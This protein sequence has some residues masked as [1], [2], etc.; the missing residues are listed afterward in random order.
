LLDKH[1]DLQAVKTKMNKIYQVQAK[2]E[3]D[4][5]RQA[6]YENKFIWGLAPL[7][8]MHLDTEYEGVPEA[9]D[10]IYSYILT[11]IAV[12]ILLIACINFVN[13]T[14]AQSLKRNKEIGIRK[15]VGSLRSQLV[16]Q[17]LGE[18]LMVCL[19]SFLAA[20]LLASLAL[21][22]FG[23]MAGK[24][25]SLGS[26]FDLQL[27]AGL[28]LLFIFTGILAGFY[29]ALVLSGLNPVQ[30]LEGRSKFG[31]NNYLAKGLV[32]LQ[33]AL[34]TFLNIATLFI[35]AQFNY[36]TKADLGYRDKDLVEF[37]ADKAIMNKP[38][39]DLMKTEYSRTPG[40]QQASY[41]NVGK[42]GGKTQAGGKEFE[43]VYERV[44]A[45]YLVTLQVP[46]L[47]GRNFSGAFPADSLNSVLVNEAFAKEAGWDDPVGKTVS[48]VEP[49][50]RA[51]YSVQI[52]GR[53]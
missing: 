20:V 28:V 30:A 31:K 35:S 36:M 1:A 13:L 21:P 48:M 37:I 51:I 50:P 42:F 17:F 3:I 11:A 10:P 49:A 8:K 24:R 4:M 45:D 7:T 38:L 16:G 22:L 12:F 6:G 33:F 18:S 53:P 29:P 2:P 25:L 34:A 39:M 52:T 40:V 43:A 19:V 23:Q 46:V 32:V 27:L 9:A 15:V 41:S 5:N 14:I 26:L 47:K 44:D